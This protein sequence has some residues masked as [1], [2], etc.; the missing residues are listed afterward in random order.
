MMIVILII[1]VLAALAIA[2]FMSKSTEAKQSEA[3]T[4]LKQ[5]YVM[6]R[7]YYQE[8]STYACDGTTASASRPL[9]GAA[10]TLASS[11]KV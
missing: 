9:N 8:F 10:T 4:I 3:R 1:S 6:Q 2:R 7:A 5:V 11:V